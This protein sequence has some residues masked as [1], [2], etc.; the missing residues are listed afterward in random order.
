MNGWRARLG[1]IVPSSNTTC[2]PEF[3]RHLP[4]GVSLH[5]A[6]MRVTEG[7]AEDLSKMTETIDRCVDLLG[8]ADV[9]VIVYASTTGS[10]LEG[11]GTDDEIGR[12][13]GES[14]DAPA[15]VTASAITRAFRTLGVES[16]AI[17]TPYIDKLNDREESFLDAA[18]FDVRAIEGLGITRNTEIGALTPADA[19]REGKRVDEPAADCLF[20]SCTNWR[21]FEIVRKLEHDLDKPVVTSNQATL[22]QALSAAGVKNH[23]VAVGS[24]FDHAP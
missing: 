12:K 10:L 7:T 24:L 15:I 17:A 9:D 19:Y 3:Y 8:T 18:G 23:D 6:R 13:I 20:V 22:W 21:T 1:L 2:E 11:P 14:A 16:L 4:A 5:T